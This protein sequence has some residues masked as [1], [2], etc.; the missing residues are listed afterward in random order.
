MNMFDDP[1]HLIAL[2]ACVLSLVGFYLVNKKPDPLKKK[3]IYGG[4]VPPNPAHLIP[5]HGEI[6]TVNRENA[7]SGSS[8][9]VAIAT[10]KPVSKRQNI[11][12]YVL[13]NPG[14]TRR[15]IEVGTG[16]KSK[17]VQGILKSLLDTGELCRK[18][19]FVDRV[20]RKHFVYS[21]KKNNKPK[22]IKGV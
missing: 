14:S 16:I 5:E 9:C 1:R 8:G 21:V 12:K 18:T 3:I 19:V 13:K 20:G 6:V 22:K 7:T 15:E 17:T 11:Y 10:V 4:V 2:S